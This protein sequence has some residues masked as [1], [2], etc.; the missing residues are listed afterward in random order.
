MQISNRH[1]NTPPLLVAWDAT[2]SSTLSHLG[3]I[4]VRLLEGPEK[5]LLD[6]S[7]HFEQ[8]VYGS[9][10]EMAQLEK[11]VSLAALGTQDQVLDSVTIDDGYIIGSST[12]RCLEFDMVL[13]R[14]TDFPGIYLEN[15]D[16]LNLASVEGASLIRL[17]TQEAQVF[18]RDTLSVTVHRKD[19]RLPAKLAYAGSFEITEANIPQDLEM[20]LSCEFEEDET[21]GQLICDIHEDHSGLRSITITRDAM[22]P[23]GPTRRVIYSELCL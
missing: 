23:E 18:T 4:S 19:A 7:S 16:D 6:I 5:T 11:L 22:T 8:P 12:T 10:A 20:D 15:P 9:S 1:E 13:H 3:A 21:D 14:R 17:P 2:R